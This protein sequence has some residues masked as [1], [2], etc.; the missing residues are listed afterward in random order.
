MSPGVKMER[1]YMD[2]KARVMAGEF[3]P[4][5]R[6]DP[7][8]LAAD[9]GTSATPVRDA[10]H[11][12]A[13]ERLVESW[14]QEGFRQPIVSEADLRDLYAWTAALLGH[15]LRA[16]AACP[17]TPEA[18]FAGADGDDYPARLARLFQSI[19]LFSGNREVRHAIGNVV[20]RSHMFRDIERQTDPM[21]LKAV[22]ELEESF[23]H[24]RWPELRTRIN[25]FHRRRAARAG[26]VGATLREREE[27][28]E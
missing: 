14:H 17:T 15:A 22:G 8:Q 9:L 28:R 10:L 18:P 7:G 2:I 23:L 26:D 25:A 5:S 20:D 3:A 16:R 27:L 24:G 4:G 6:I 11:R 21:C 13:G 19:A 1:V 12:L